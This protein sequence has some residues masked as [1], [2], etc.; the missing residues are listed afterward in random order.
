VLSKAGGIG[1]GNMA[2]EDR[3]IHPEF[4]AEIDGVELGRPVDRAVVDKI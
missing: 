3:P 1:E 2:I 4:V